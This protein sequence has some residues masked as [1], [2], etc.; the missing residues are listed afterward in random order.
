MKEKEHKQNVPGAP[1]DVEHKQ[2]VPGPGTGVAETKLGAPPVGRG[3]ED[4]T[5]QEDFEIPR[6]RVVQFTSE[7]AQAEKTED[8]I[9]PGTFIN[10]LNKKEISP[11]FCPIYRFKTYTRWNPRKKDD[12]NYDPAFEPGDMIFTST[13][14]AD[15]RVI[16][17]VKFGPN[18][19]PPAVTQAINFLCY[20]E[21]QN[22]P[23]V[24]TF[25]KTS[26]RGG[27]R[28][29][30]LLLEAG[31]DMFSNKFRVVVNLEDKAGTKYYVMDVRASGKAN[32][33]EFALCEKWYTQFRGVDIA[34]KVQK[35]HGAEGEHQ[36]GEQK[37]WTE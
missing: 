30:T 34:S 23:L 35:E 22:M 6:A 5:T 7:E 17:G 31:G 2:V 25:A 12:P 14:R 20:F 29:N 16:E 15:P 9:N 10:G 3:H 1:A 37:Q 24:L 19:E 11:L 18:G 33:Q 28:L 36:P 13:N 21:G 32:E 8:R 26:Y 27:K 4:E